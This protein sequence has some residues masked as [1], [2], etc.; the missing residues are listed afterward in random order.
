MEKVKKPDS[1][2]LFP[3]MQ[4]GFQLRRGNKKNGKRVFD[5]ACHDSN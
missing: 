3:S 1:T 5:L 2:M 4:E